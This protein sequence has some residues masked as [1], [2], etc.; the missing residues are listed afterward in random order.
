MISGAA[1]D[2]AVRL[3]RH[4]HQHPELRF[5]EHRTSQIVADLLDAA[6]FD[7]RRGIAGTG[8]VGSITRGD[9]TSHVAARSDIDALPIPDL[10]SVPY[11]ST[12]QDVSHA[13]GHDVHTAVV[14]ITAARIA[15]SPGF[16]GRLTVIFQPAEEIPFGQLSGASEMIKAGALSGPPIDAIFALHCWPSLPAGVIGLNRGSAMAAKDAF[17]IVFDGR[18]SHASAPA[19]GRD[20]IAAICSLVSA[21][22]AS[23]GRRVN[24]EDL[25]IL[26]VGTIKGGLTQ[27]IVP[28]HAEI[29]GT[30]RTIDPA[31]RESLHKVVESAVEGTASVWDVQPSLVWAN[32]M[33]AVA[34]NRDLFALAERILPRLLG[35][36]NFRELNNPGLATDD[37]A[38]FAMEAPGLYL[39][40]GTRGHD[41]G[42]EPLHTS[43]FDVDETCLTTGIEALSH[44]LFEASDSSIDGMS[45]ELPDSVISTLAHTFGT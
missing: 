45:D 6:G 41:V 36:D 15:A 28:D 43:C 27:S 31:V 14:A 1:I 12:V 11:T 40:L 23:V 35:E 33:P 38:L 2:Q 17:Q 37:F 10:K 7:V 13:C 9:S 4:L 26:N 20:S 18:A 16:R 29:T 3:R 22:H 34:N 25:R 5:E 30:I 19:S 21:L 24:P 32:S 44:L 8:V 39:K 42:G